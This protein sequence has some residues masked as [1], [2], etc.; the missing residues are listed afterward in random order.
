MFHEFREPK[1]VILDPMPEFV[2]AKLNT[3]NAL[4]ILINVDHH[5][6]WMCVLDETGEVVN[7]PNNKLRFEENWTWG[8][9]AR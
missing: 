1:P 7:V 5:N 9:F 8:R 4:G 6:L 3:A 2:K